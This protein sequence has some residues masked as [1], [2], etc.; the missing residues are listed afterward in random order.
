MARG[1][2]RGPTLGE[3]GEQALRDGKAVVTSAPRQ[4]ADVPQAVLREFESRMTAGEEK[5]ARFLEAR[6]IRGQILWWEFEPMSFRLGPANAKRQEE[7]WYTPDFGV[8]LADR[9]YELHEYKGD[10]WQEASR[11][12]IKAA[13]RL[14]PMFRF[15]GI[16][17]R[18]FGYEPEEFPA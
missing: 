15:W 6:K 12:R 1:G 3:V 13:A 4:L 2:R 5:Y 18:S 8:L 17:P 14:F 10:D 11:V 9:S 16:Q 7:A